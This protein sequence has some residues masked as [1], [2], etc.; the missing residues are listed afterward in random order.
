MNHQRTY[1]RFVLFIF[2][3]SLWIFIVGCSDT[4]GTSGQTTSVN[5]ITRHHDEI[6]PN[7]EIYVKYFVTDFPGYEQFE[8]FDTVL[9]SSSSG[10]ASLRNFPLGHHWFVAIG[11]D[12]KIREQV[13]GNI[14]LT[15]NLRN[16]QVDTIMYVGEE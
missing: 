12:E 6:I 3:T 15:F 4:F 11:F 14:D 5:F 1:R 10:R 13:I 9:I 2:V 16:L 8:T 7:I